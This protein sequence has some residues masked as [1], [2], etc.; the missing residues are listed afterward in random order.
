MNARILDASE[1]DKL[2]HTEL[3]VLLPHMRPE[4]TMIVV[5]EDD[6]GAVV[7]SIAALR[8]THLEGLWIDPAHRNGGVGRALIRALLP[9]ARCWGGSWAIGGA[10]SDTMRD[11]LT[12]VGAVKIPAEFYALS[13]A[14]PVREVS[15]CRQS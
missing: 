14:G 9:L 8:V 5:V 3:P 6:A 1:W 7:A 13:L 11:F 15:P 2:A 4:D 12:R 10:A